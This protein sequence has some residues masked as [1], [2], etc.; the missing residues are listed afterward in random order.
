MSQGSE[1]RAVILSLV[2][3][4]PTLLSRAVLYTAVTRAKELLIIVGDEEAVAQMVNNNRTRKRY[5]GLKS[6]LL[7]AADIYRT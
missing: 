4:A 6:R 3:S 2:K 1:Y 5:S 7:G